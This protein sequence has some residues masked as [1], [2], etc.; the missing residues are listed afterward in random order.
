M[1]K[2]DEHTKQTGWGVAEAVV[3][4]SASAIVPKTTI[5]ARTTGF[6]R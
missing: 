5:R 4:G 1:L 2:R 6:H 3:L